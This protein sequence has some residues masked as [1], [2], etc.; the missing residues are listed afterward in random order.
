MSISFSPLNP[1][2]RLLF[3]PGPTMVEPR[4]YQAM[5]KPVVSHLD[6]YFFEVVED[7]R[8]LLRA[9]FG[10]AN[11][12]TLAMSGTG[13]AGMQTAVANFVEPGS[14]YA[15]L[16]NGF[17]C[18]RLTEMGRRQG[19]KVARLE[20]PW[21][22]SFEEAEAAEFIRKERPNVVAF[23]QAETSTGVYQ[24]SKTICEAAHEVGA[25][26][27]ADCVTSLGAMPVDLDANGIDIAYSC[28]QKGLSCPPGLA[29]VSV[30]AR[31]MD[32]LRN[33]KTTPADWYLDLKLLADY[34][35]GAH[36]YHHTAPI[37]LF[38]ALRE[39][40]LSIAGEG[41]EKRQMRHRKSHEAFVAGSGA[42]GL[43]MLVKPGHRLW[44]LNTPRVPEGIED[45]KV[46]KRLLE[47]GDIEILGGFGP[48]AGKVFRVGIMGPLATEE[49]VLLLVEGM[50]KALREEGFSPK[51]S[52]VEA[53]KAYYAG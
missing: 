39:G 49:N 32:W 1:P 13:S 5:T 14:K 20:K 21:G 26:V 33:R 31:A 40:L 12:F 19:A 4:V 36:R 25:L 24:S 50:E 16:A 47:W 43:E 53:V 42:M 17:F 3:G 30:S 6:P 28:T 7:C 46:R 52:G 8:K 23:V 35:E 45:L 41:I 10:T 29:P 34:Y 9:A 18:D 37:S 22:E 48:L 51:G 44:N 15:V 38:Y 27:I 2:R 11:E